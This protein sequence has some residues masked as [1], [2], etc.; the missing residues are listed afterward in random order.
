MG[1][2]RKPS[3]CFRCEEPHPEYVVASSTVAYCFQCAVFA[4]LNSLSHRVEAVGA[5]VETLHGRLDAIGYDVSEVL[6]RARSQSE[7]D[8]AE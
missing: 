6:E 7:S 2:E 4:E 5:R 3:R 1:M 8:D